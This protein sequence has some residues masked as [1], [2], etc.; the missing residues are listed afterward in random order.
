MTENTS[1]AG[2]TVIV[3]GQESLSPAAPA[4]L[5]EALAQVEH[6][7]DPDTVLRYARCTLPEG[8]RP[9]GVCWPRSTAEVQIVVQ[10]ARRLGL[11]L[12]PISCGRNWG[13][14]DRCAGRD[15]CLIVDLSRMRA[16]VTVDPALAY[17]V[18]EP[19][20]TQGMLFDHLR[21][22]YPTLQM[23]CTGAGPDASVIGNIAERGF[24]H[25]RYGDRLLSSCNFEVVLGSGEVVRTGM[26]AWPGCLTAEL[27][28]H[29]LGPSLHGLFTQSA[30][31][32]ITQ[33][34]VWLMP[35]QPCRTT[36]MITLDEDPQFPAL[37]EAL[38]PLRLA[39][40]LPSTIH[41]FNGLRLVGAVARF[42]YDR[43]DGRTSLDLIHPGGL[44][45]LLA[46][47]GLPAWACSAYFDGRPDLVRVRLRALRQAVR[48]I[49]GCRVIA[50]TRKRALAWQGLFGL[51]PWLPGVVRARAGLTKFLAT[52]RLQEGE[53]DH[54]TLGGGHWR[55]RGACGRDLDALDSGAGMYWIS[56]LLPM[57]GAEVTAVQSICWPIFH[58][59]GFEYQ[60]TFSATSDRALCAV[61][62][63]P[64]DRRDADERQRARSCHDAL[65]AALADAGYIPYRAGAPTLDLLRPHAPGHWDL[66]TALGSVCDPDGVFKAGKWR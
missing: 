39:G 28:H 31:G 25:S 46:E 53:P 38:R 37:V 32:I 41:C 60:V 7:C 52:V 1:S 16:I 23:D 36:V 47:Y 20:V 9:L 35:K 44:T 57:T 64:F 6:A 63:V 48:R 55:G 18:I 26:G 61:T 8:T 21:R 11:V 29:G 66:S 3:A 33:A 22:E 42:P 43:H 45:A 54:A 24:G 13:Y 19:G 51:I 58:R 30:L 56:P 65:V 27:Q 49:P 59:Y 62:T 12:H 14:G 40:G 50:L 17:A 4:N 10:A 34:T 15:G 2:P 5:V